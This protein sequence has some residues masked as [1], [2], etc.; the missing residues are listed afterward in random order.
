MADISSG[1][2]KTNVFM[3][4]SY[5]LY[6]QRLQRDD[7]KSEAWLAPGLAHGFLR[8]RHTSDVA[9]DAF[10]RVCSAI[11]TFLTR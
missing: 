4:V 8:V 2:A 11:S 1:G 5:P 10:N 7:V 6:A 9:G 3:D